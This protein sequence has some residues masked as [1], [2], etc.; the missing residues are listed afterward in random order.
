M[1]PIALYPTTIHQ[2]QR[3]AETG[4][5]YTLDPWTSDTDRYH[6]ETGESDRV[7]ILAADV[8][9]YLGQFRDLIA[10]RRARSFDQTRNPTVT[11]ELDR[12]ISATGT[13][14]DR[15]WGHTRRHKPGEVVTTADDL[16]F[17]L[18]RPRTEQQTA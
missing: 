9:L 8:T 3:M 12:L 10:E 7:L 14:L 17:S 11:C 2:S 18:T 6:G 15:T 16:R 13:I 1:Q 5:H 4:S